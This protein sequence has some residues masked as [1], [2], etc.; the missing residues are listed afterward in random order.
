[1]R[2]EPYTLM[3]CVVSRSVTLRNPPLLSVSLSDKGRTGL[4]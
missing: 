3:E 2:T 4:Q 1:M